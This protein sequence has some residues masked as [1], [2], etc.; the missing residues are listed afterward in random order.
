[1]MPAS[2]FTSSLVEEESSSS[3]KLNIVLTC[4]LKAA[5]DREA[6]ISMMLVTELKLTIHKS[7]S[8]SND[9]VI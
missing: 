1:M 5:R 3:T 8:S 7:M 9:V 2:V 4:Y 6:G